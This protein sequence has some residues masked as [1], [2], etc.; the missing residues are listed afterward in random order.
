MIT[1]RLLVLFH[2]DEC[3]AMLL[4]VRTDGR[5]MSHR[6]HG[7]RT[8]KGLICRYRRLWLLLV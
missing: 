8:H 5:T 6:H 2:D 4:R 3:L 1:E 7:H